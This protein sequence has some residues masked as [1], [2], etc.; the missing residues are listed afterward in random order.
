MNSLVHDIQ[1]KIKFEAESG[2]SQI[3]VDWTKAMEKIDLSAVE[4][5]PIT[6]TDG[7]VTSRYKHVPFTYCK[8]RR[9]Y[10]N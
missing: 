3:D 6:I 5:S 8:Y 7:I 10:Q 1:K 4:M 2:A 9:D